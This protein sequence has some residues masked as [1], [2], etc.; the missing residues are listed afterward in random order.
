MK[1]E[2]APDSTYRI[3]KLHVCRM[4]LPRFFENL[5]IAAHCISKCFRN[6]FSYPVKAVADDVLGKVMVQVEAVKAKLYQG[7]KFMS[8]SHCQELNRSTSKLAPDW[9]HKSEQ[10]IRSQVSKLT[11]LW[12]MT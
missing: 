1:G 5:F 3:E 10:P 12:T 4:Y 9:L 2:G 11:Q 8:C 7:W 6:N